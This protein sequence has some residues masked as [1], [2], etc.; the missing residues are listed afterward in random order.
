MKIHSFKESDAEAVAALSNE[1]SF[2]FQHAKVTPAF[3]RRMCAH[4]T[5]KM[6]VLKEHGAIVGF[7]GVNFRSKKAAE[8]GPI[9]VKNERRM[10]GLGRLLVMR[11]FEHVEPLNCDSLWVK[12]KSSNRDAQKFFTSLGFK[13]TGQASVR[14]TP[15][16]MMEHR[17]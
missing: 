16:V 13:K 11:V 4:R 7:C 12:V 14:G 2:A 3:L 10:H 9:C 17:V 5:Y 15:V 1:N 8:L 6:F